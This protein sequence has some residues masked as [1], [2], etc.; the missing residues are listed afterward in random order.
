[1][2]HG[3]WLLCDKSGMINQSFMQ[4]TLKHYGST[5]YI[6]LAWAMIQKSEDDCK[7]QEQILRRTNENSE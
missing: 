6:I 3:V 2:H 7:K 4:P 1:M 5:D